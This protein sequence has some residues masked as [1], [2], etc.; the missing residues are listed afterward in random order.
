MLPQA[1]TDHD[2]FAVY[3][4]ASGPNKASNCQAAGDEDAPRNP[5]SLLTALLT[6]PPV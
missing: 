6:D 5:R 1:K 4:A 3:D 2:E